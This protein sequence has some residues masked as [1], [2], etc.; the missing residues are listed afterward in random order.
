[1]NGGDKEARTPVILSKNPL[2]C[3]RASS[4]NPTFC[5][6]FYSLVIFILNQIVAKIPDNSAGNDDRWH[7]P[8]CFE[9]VEAN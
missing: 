7:T 9:E 1:M 8:A 2:N 6:K 5:C 4:R 3:I